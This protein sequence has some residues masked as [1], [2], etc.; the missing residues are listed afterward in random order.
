MLINGYC[1]ML[2]NWYCPMLINW[3]C[4]MLINGYCPMLING[5]YWMLTGNHYNRLQRTLRSR[6][7]SANRLI[8]RIMRGRIRSLGN[9]DDGDSRSVSRRSRGRFRSEARKRGGKRLRRRQKRLVQRQVGLRR[10]VS[11]LEDGKRRVR[12]RKRLLFGGEQ[13]FILF[14]P[15]IE[16]PHAKN[17]EGNDEFCELEYDK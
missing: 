5:Y 10:L 15:G 2:I 11:T 6:A 3:Y 13:F 4:P 9:D 17:E 14:F 8:R 7:P 1:P 16:E 12:G